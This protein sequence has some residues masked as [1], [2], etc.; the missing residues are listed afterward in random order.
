[1]TRN[2]MLKTRI[3][4]SVFLS[5]IA[6][7]YSKAQ[8]PLPAPPPCLYE[9]INGRWVYQL[10]CNDND[11]CTSNTCLIDRN[12]VR[13]CRYDEITCDDNDICTIDEC[14]PSSVFPFYACDHTYLGCCCT[15]NRMSAQDWAHLQRIEYRKGW[16]RYEEQMMAKQDSARF[17]RTAIR[18][19]DG[20]RQE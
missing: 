13:T 8:C 17:F 3:S 2:T 7:C 1:M 5:A 19:H 16:I 20:K 14:E 18:H 15:M 11:P 10:F 6:I 9:C 12:G 4:L